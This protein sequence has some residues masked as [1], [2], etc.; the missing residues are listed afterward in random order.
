[1]TS[2][3]GSQGKRVDIS[4]HFKGMGSNF[5]IIIQITLYLISSNA[6]H[7]SYKPIVLSV[8]FHLTFI[9]CMPF[10]CFPTI[11]LM[12]SLLLPLFHLFSH[13]LSPLH[14]TPTM[15]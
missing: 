4:L 8:I 7:E 14:L 1:M 9:F 6:L 12:H 10:Y 2:R 11:S 3:A 13:C 15:F 5:L